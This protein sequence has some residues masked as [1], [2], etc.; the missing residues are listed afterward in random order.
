MF[1]IR[2]CFMLF[3][4]GRAVAVTPERT[5]LPPHRLPPACL[6]L[7][8]AGCLLLG[9]LPL[10]RSH[11]LGNS[12]QLVGR[13]ES[14]A[15]LKVC[16]PNWHMCEADYS[17]LEIGSDTVWILWLISFSGREAVKQRVSCCLGWV[18]DLCSPGS[19]TGFCRHRCFLACLSV[20]RRRRQ[21]VCM[22][23]LW[24]WKEKPVGGKSLTESGANFSSRA[25]IT[26]SS[27][28]LQLATAK[29]SLLL[30]CRRV[31]SD[32]YLNS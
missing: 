27:T 25:S 9:P 26:C 21:I 3:G 29:H 23:E 18:R 16:R 11:H 14:A 17:C 28:R 24:W 19:Q 8:L 32:D 20:W 6:L 30:I 4:R 13:K 7:H 31:I 10:A 1:C 5:S 12:R 22:D 15:V 2:K